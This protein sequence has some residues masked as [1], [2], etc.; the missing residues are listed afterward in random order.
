[1]RAMGAFAATSFLVE[2][3]AS[4][5]ISGEASDTLVLWAAPKGSWKE[6]DPVPGLSPRPAARSLAFR[7]GPDGGYLWLALPDA[8]ALRVR[9]HGADGRRL[10]SVEKGR[11]APGY[12]AIP[13]APAGSMPRGLLF[14]TV[15]FPGSP[16][17]YRTVLKVLRP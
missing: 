11:L 17:G 5:E 6:G 14:V 8:S 3:G 7:D 2:E 9:A 16:D 1:M 15:E 13:L 12:H 4:L 10:A